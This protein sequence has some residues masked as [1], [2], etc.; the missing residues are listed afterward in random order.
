[1]NDSREAVLLANHEHA[2]CR[3]SAGVVSQVYEGRY[4]VVQAQPCEARRAA[5]CL[6]EPEVGDTVLFARGDDGHW[7]VAVLVAA[8][9]RDLQLRAPTLH[10]QADQL[11][12][13][14]Q[15]LR[16]RSQDWRAVHTQVHL[17]AN[18][19]SGQ[20]A[21]LDWLSD[22]VSA[23]VNL[24]VSRSRNSLREVSEIDSLRCGN[25]DLRVDETL[26]MSTKTGVM[27]AQALMKID[28][29][30]VHIG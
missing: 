22:R 4:V 23:F 21:V 28:G 8:G 13:S 15:T 27:S 1:M 18:H 20:V 25:Y 6:V 29:T 3:L 24:L 14:A 17:A 9:Q 7:I 19:V 2:A 26:A 10:A 12:L 5:S 30:Q 16:T 11:H